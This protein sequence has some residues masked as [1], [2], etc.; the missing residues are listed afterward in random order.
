MRY[1]VA[2]FF[3][4]C[5]G[6]DLGT[7]GG[8][9]YIGR[10]Y[11][12]LPFD[13]V[14]ASDINA[15]AVETYNKNFEHPADVADITKVDQETA[16]GDIDVLIGG[17]PCQ[18]FSIINRNRNDTDDRALLY[19]QILKCLRLKQPKAF[20]CENVK[21]LVNLNGGE[22]IKRIVEE[23]GATGYNVSYKLFNAADYGIPQR[24]QR[25]LIVGVRKDIAS[26]YHFP[27]PTTEDKWVPLK[28][29]LDSVEHPDKKL[30]FTEAQVRKAKE[31]K[32]AKKRC[33]GMTLD[34]PCLTITAHISVAHVNSSEPIVE[35]DA[36]SN[37]YRRFSVRECA[38]IQSFPDTF[39]FENTKKSLHQIGNAV[40]PVLMWHVMKSLSETLLAE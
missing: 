3:C 27:E 13:I 31:S 21:G 1:K 12:R 16:I 11:E 38:R 40:P 18:S 28:E 2:S 30:Y 22:V 19:K 15:A 32:Y 17:F 14:Y 35:I 36:K 8:F 39:E 23:M 25:V 37:K 5:G 9:D 7:L 33:V 24:R 4:G 34:K 29:V 6:S 20:V 10:H 26:E